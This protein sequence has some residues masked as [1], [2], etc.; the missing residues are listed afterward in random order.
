MSNK[1]DLYLESAVASQS[2]ACIA[3]YQGDF[4]EA[5]HHAKDAAESLALAVPNDRD[6]KAFSESIQHLESTSPVIVRLA[7]TIVYAMFITVCSDE[8]GGDK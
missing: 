4:P 1:E 3:L 2:K 7:V 8:H 5:L 6:I